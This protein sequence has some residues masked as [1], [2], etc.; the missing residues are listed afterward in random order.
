MFRVVIVEDERILRVGLIHSIDWASLK[1]VIVGEAD[2][3]RDGLEL[4]LRERPDI[5]IADIC[6]PLLN[7][8]DMIGEASK[9]YRFW[10]ILLT[11]YSEFEY[12]QQAI[13]LQVFEYLMKP[14]DEDILREKLIQLTEKIQ[15]ERLLDK[16]MVHLVSGNMPVDGNLQIHVLRDTGNYYV[17][18]ALKEIYQSYM[19]KLSVE[20][21][22]EQLKISSSY[23]SRKFKKVTKHSFLDYLNQYRVIKAIQLMGSGKYR[24]GEVAGLAGFSSEKH[25]Y[26][27][28]RKYTQRTPSEF[29]KEQVSIVSTGLD[30]I[31]DGDN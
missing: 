9:V 19:E 28:F 25:F 10:S 5:V 20:T 7:G 29:V 31:R 24:F 15:R 12:A 30:I 11:S 1:C 17:N 23:L 14:V 21:V 26:S 27:V 6:M 2:N 18:E 3:G 16:M 13:S 8:L 4:I 22:A